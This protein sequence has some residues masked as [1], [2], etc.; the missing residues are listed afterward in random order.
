MKFRR[1]ELE[2][3]KKYGDKSRGCRDALQAP[4]MDRGATSPGRQEAWG[5]WRE[6]GTESPWS[7]RKEQ[8]PSATLVFAHETFCRLL[9]PTTV[10]EK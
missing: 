7:F 8:R 4:E 10:R 2:P 9:T 6:Q 1:G 5:S 3:E